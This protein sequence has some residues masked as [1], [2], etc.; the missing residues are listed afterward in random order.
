[1]RSHGGTMDILNLSMLKDLSIPLPSV[2]EQK[3]IVEQVNS[4]F[5]IA[6]ELE[7]TIETN[8]KRAERLRHRILQQAFAGDLV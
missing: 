5:S 2:K 8:L 6:E 3:L 1:M 4:L 7:T